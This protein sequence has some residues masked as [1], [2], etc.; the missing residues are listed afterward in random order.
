VT[1]LPVSL[2]AVAGI[3]LATAA[4]GSGVAVALVPRGLAW[5]EERLAWG[6]AAGLAIL[7]GSVGLAFA[8]HSTPG[9][10]WFL[11]LSA[12]VGLPARLVRFRREAPAPPP[13]EGGRIAGILLAIVIVGIALYAL[14]ALT[15]PMW[16]N[17]YVA[18]WGFKGKT[19]F[20]E[21]HIPD[22]LF[23]W[24]ALSFSHPEYPLGLPLL[25][26][27]IAFLLGRWDDHA[28]AL[29]FPFLQVATLL[30]LYGWLRRRGADRTLALAAA[31]LLSQFEPLYRAFT[32]G[33]AEVPLSF[34]VLLLGTAL[35]DRI[36]RTDPGASRRLALAALVCAATKNEGL[37]FVA[38]AFLV[39]ALSLFARKGFAA[40]A[41][42]ILALPA[43]LVVA[44]HRLIRGSLPLRDFDFTLLAR[45]ADLAPR[46]GQ[47]L[48]AVV[49]GTPAA[50]WV[51]LAALAVLVAAGRATPAGSALLA[52]AACGLAAYLFLPALAVEG[53]AWLVETA[54]FRTTAA[55]A[56]LLAAGVTVRLLPVFG[57]STGSAPGPA[58]SAA[59]PGPPTPSTRGS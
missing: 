47:S 30:L 41:A 56:P 37:F 14:R 36:E 43:A 50:A 34:G 39:A 58:A 38:A 5:R 15:E 57:G 9:W 1:G 51:G 27:G 49:R 53:P 29:L 52:L 12:I 7:G 20:A 25:Y 23:R 42:A 4:I 28:M 40:R 26:A 18:I 16:A 17:D 22:R 19:F 31:V 45:P 35:S 44:A 11:L 54:F 32:T 2:L 33:M 10:L 46:I 48:E 13:S 3:L 59:S 6:F 24:Q 55:L 8:L 21:R